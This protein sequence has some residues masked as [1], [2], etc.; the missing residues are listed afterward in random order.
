MDALTQLKK[1]APYLDPHLLLFLLQANIGSD[2]QALQDQIKSK[3][4]SADPAKA[5]TLTAEAEKKAS[6]LITL[7][8]DSGAVARMRKDGQFNFD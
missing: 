6:K 1:L 7:L 4:I 5:K 8:S 2:S 3:L